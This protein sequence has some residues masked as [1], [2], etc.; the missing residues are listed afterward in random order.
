[1]AAVRELVLAGAN[2]NARDKYGATPLM[3]ATLYG[4]VGIVELLLYIA[5]H[6]LGIKMQIRRTRAA[7]YHTQRPS[8]IYS[9]TLC[10]ACKTTTL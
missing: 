1:M 4:Y 10:G 2:V 7:A 5:G 9:L 3:A 8:T 6:I